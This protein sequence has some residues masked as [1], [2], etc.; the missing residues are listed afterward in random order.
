MKKNQYIFLILLLWISSCTFPQYIWPQKDIDTE[1]INQLTLEKKILI[2]SRNSE[3]KNAI[4]QR[5]KDAFQDQDVYIKIVGINNLEYEDPNQY[6]ATVIMNTAMGWKIDKNVESFLVKYGK[7]SSIIVLTT[8]NG[9]D[10]LPNLE[11]RNIDAVSTASIIDK[12]DQI[13]DTI[14]T[15]L[16]IILQNNRS[17]KGKI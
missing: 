11:G 14:I 13:A 10:I 9:G 12:T 4:L 6:S 3:F 15:K 7:L 2:A 17:I 1:E 5:I 8:S 16:K